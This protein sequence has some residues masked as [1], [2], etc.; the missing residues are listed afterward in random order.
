MYIFD[1]FFSI[2]CEIL[3]QI[4]KL[5]G[6]SFFYWTTLNSMFHDEAWLHFKAT[7]FGPQTMSWLTT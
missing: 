7:T 6:K 3:A 1:T 2:F 4:I 5:K